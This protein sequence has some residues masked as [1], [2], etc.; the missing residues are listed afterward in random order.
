MNATTHRLFH[1][2]LVFIFLLPFS[3]KAQPNSALK[4]LVVIFD[5]LREDYI[6]PELMPNLYRLGMKGGWGRQ[7]HSVFPT[8][9]RVNA[10]SFATGSYPNK[11]GILGN[12]I[13][14]PGLISS[15]VF[16]T[17]NASELMKVAEVTSDKLLTTPSLGEILAAQGKRM[18]VFSSGST[19]QAFLQYHKV[20]N[21]AIINPDLILPSSFRTKVVAAVGEPP[22]AAKPNEERHA[23]IVEAFEHF[24]LTD[25]SPEVS[26]IWFSD[27]DAT[28]HAEGIGAPLTLEAIGFVDIQ[29]GRVLAAM[30][31]HGMR[32]QFNIMITTDHGFVTQ[33]G[34]E[35]LVDFLVDENLKESKV[36]DDVIIA[37]GAIFVKNHDRKKIQQIVSSLQ[38]QEWVGAIFSKSEK[39]G[40]INGWVKGTLSFEAIFWGHKDRAAD[41][42][43]DV[44]WSD[45]KN[46][47]GYEGTS[48]ASGIAGH[49]SSSPYEIH[50]PLL[51]DGPSFKQAIESQYPTSNID[52][53][54]TILH[55]QGI[56]VP[57]QMNGRVLKELL[58]GSP[59]ID[60]KPKQV[61]HQ[62]S[63]K[64]DWGEYQLLL[65][66]TIFDDHVYFDYT[67]VI[68]KYYLISD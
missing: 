5:G 23:W 12:S 24:V 44:N 66:Q 68:R 51:F 65:Q 7:N 25:E 30:E 53:T 62:V 18:M 52:I 14:L 40:S 9:T 34:K 15:G 27:P 26:T 60:K 2:I 46:E 50:I 17:G 55:L 22:P 59:D 64:K 67:K 1:L 20:D 10:P 43:V 6:T 31:K 63:V 54:P 19:G 45:Q 35:S 21:G 58:R 49:G 38:K 13:Y 4:T 28:A 48:F 16:N 41:L 61:T 57:E 11:H 3:T 42:L 36:S 56:E 33:I 47:Y 8:V 32:D 29:L 39:A 37:G